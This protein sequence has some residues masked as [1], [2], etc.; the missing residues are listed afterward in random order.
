[1]IRDHEGDVVHAAAVKL[2]YVLDAFQSEVQACL[3]GAKL[4]S[5]IGVGRLIL[6]TDSLMLKQALEISSHR[7]A[8]TGGLISEL[9]SLLSTSFISVSISYA[10]RNCNR[11][12]HAL[13]ALGCKCPQGDDLLW[14]STPTAV[15]GLVASDCIASLS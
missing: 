11:V 1:M 9:Q 7:L 10:S 4:T 6:E 13:A 12:A 5:A 15:E 3:A 2:P 14:E 8:A